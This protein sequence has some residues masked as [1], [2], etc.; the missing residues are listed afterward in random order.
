M[1]DSVNTNDVKGMVPVLA[2]PLK[3]GV[4]QS[5]CSTQNGKLLVVL[6]GSIVPPQCFE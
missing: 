5:R 3:L 4:A 1:A 2:L 6:P